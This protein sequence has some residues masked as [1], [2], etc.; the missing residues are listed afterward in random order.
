MSISKIITGLCNIILK[1]KVFVLQTRK[2]HFTCASFL[3]VKK[4]AMQIFIFHR[5]EQRG[6]IFQIKDHKCPC[7]AE[8]SLYIR[9]FLV[10]NLSPVELWRYIIGK[11]S[12]LFAFPPKFNR[13]R[14]KAYQ[15]L[16]AQCKVENQ[17][18]GWT[19]MIIP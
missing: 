3:C 19:D 15:K 7:S 8:L 16:S 1:R 17:L 10:S 12:V 14:V 6:L 13:Q 18:N 5:N 11:S 9:H 4:Y 2:E